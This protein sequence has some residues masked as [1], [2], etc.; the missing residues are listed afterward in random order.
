MDINFK[1]KEAQVSADNYKMVYVNIEG[2]D[3]DDVLENFPIQY[4]ID[5]IGEEKLL[6]AI[7]ED[8]V[9]EYFDLTD[10]E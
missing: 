9:K 7:G 4:I 1:C 5:A 3:I 6:D 8:R 2:V 10:K